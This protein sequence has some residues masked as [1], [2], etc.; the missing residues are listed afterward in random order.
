MILI[1]SIDNRI[2]F[3][4]IIN[5]W[6]NLINKFMDISKFQIIL[7]GNKKD[8]N[9]ERIVSEEEG[10]KVAENYNFKFFETSAITGENV[11]ETF[12]KLFEIIVKKFKSNNKNN[13]IDININKNIHNNNHNNN[14]IDKEGKCII[15]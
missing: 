8:L 1:Y 10:R 5:Q 13:N 14:K 4:N 3:E 6:I 15:I 2:S 11:N 7:V 12:Q 9:D